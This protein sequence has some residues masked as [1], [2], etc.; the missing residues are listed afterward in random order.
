MNLYWP[1]SIAKP[2]SWRLFHTVQ[3]GHNY[4]E[5][6]TITIN[7]WLIQYEVELTPK[8]SKP[9]TVSSVWVRTITTKWVF[10]PS[11]DAKVIFTTSLTTTTTYHFL[12]LKMEIEWKLLR[13]RITASSLR[14]KKKGFPQ[15]WEE[16]FYLV[17]GQEPWPGS[18][19]GGR[20]K[21]LQKQND[22]D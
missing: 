19:L 12:L 10:F 11:K 6:W 4:H 8:M 20:S 14:G 15:T 13:Q 7:N 16:L 18:N 17:T 5:P 21:R 3:C 2:D 1:L 22:K 9:Y